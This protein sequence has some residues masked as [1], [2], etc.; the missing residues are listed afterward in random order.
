MEVRQFLDEVVGNP[1]SRPA[2]TSVA[3][4]RD[5]MTT[6]LVVDDSP[7]VRGLL[8]TVLRAAEIEAVMAENGLEAL[9]AAHHVQPAV[10]V[11]DISM[12]VLDGI[13]AT[14]LLK[15]SA[16]TRHIPVI[17][18]TSTPQL[19][20]RVAGEKLFAYVLTKPVVP[21]ALVAVLEQV[22]RADQGS[23]ARQDQL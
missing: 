20:D 8:S 4:H 11:M 2:R 12:P 9:L 15:A 19:C 17:A 14:R 18:H 16:I 10:V 3:D 13:G 23:A 1:V 21:N 22:I 6:V 5:R 7:E